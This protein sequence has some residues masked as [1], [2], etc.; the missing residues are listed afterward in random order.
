MN[1]PAPST[2]TLYNYD[3]DRDDAA[4]LYIAKGGSKSDYSDLVKYQN[5]RSAILPAD[6]LIDGRVRITFWSAIK[7]FKEE[8]KGQVRFF[9]RDY[10]GSDYHDIAGTTLTEEEWQDESST[11][12]KK[13]VEITANNYTVPS[14][15]QLELKIVVGNGSD[16]DM[17]FAY[18]TT[19]YP[20]R[21]ELP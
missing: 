19:N 3:T 10:D 17:W 12:V 8:K 18:D 13:T 2:S 7:D 16:D 1:T 15:H 6:L 4:G 11:W 21:I 14:G 20:T 9:L 5:W